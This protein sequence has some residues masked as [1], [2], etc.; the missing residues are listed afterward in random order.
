MLQRPNTSCLFFYAGMQFDA[1]GICSFETVGLLPV[2]L[3]KP[4]TIS[5]PHGLTS[6]VGIKGWYV[7]IPRS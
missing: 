5:E 3:R 4:L 2:T 1:Q 6:K 7:S